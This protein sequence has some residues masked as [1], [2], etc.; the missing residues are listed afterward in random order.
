MKKRSVRFCSVLLSLL[1]LT[2][3][4]TMLS[5]SAAEVT[6]S[7]S[8]QGEIFTVTEDENGIRFVGPTGDITLEEDEARD[9]VEVISS[10]EDYYNIDSENVSLSK[11]NTLL[12]ASASLPDSVDNSQSKYFPEIGNQGS[13]GS[14]TCWAQ[15]Y[16]QFTYTMNKDMGV[17]T[18]PENAFSPKWTYNLVNWGDAD[19]GSGQTDV[20]ELMREIGVV[21]QGTVPY[22]D[23]VTSWSPQEDI[24][25]QALR[26]RV[27]SYQ[28]FDSFGEEKSQVTSVDDED[29]EAVKTA[30]SNGDVL[31]FSTH[32]NSWVTGKLKT[33]SKAPGNASHANE[34]VVLHQ[35]GAIGGHRMTIVGYNDN[36]W[37]DI[38]GNNTVDDGEM[39]AFKIANSWGKSYANSGFIWVAYDAL[40]QV[41]CVE[42]AA[43]VS[44]RKTPITYVARMDVEPYDSKSSIYLKYTLNTSCR[45]DVQPYLIAEKDGTEHSV[46]TLAKT[47]IGVEGGNQFSFDGTTNSNDG[48]MLYPLDSVIEDISTENLAD[49]NW[50]VRFVDKTAD[51][52]VLTVKDTQIVDETTNTVYKPASGTYPIKLDG[53]ET[54]IELIETTI[55]HAVVYYRGYENAQLTYKTNGSWKTVSMEENIERDGYVHKYVI[56]LG[57]TSTATFYF[58]DGNGKTDNNSGKYYTAGKGISYFVTENARQAVTVTL[59]MEKKGSECIDVNTAIGFVAEASGGYAPYTYQFITEDLVTNTVTTSTYKTSNRTGYFPRSEGDHRITVNVKD[60]SGAIATATYDIYIDDKP[61][62]FKSFEMTTSSNILTGQEVGFSARTIN[63]NL[64]YIGYVA[65]TYDI[66]VEKDG[67]ECYS[68]TVK[69]D[70]YDMSY[71]YT[72]TNFTWTPTES[73]SYTVKISSTDSKSEYAEAT[74]SFDV[75]EF[76]GTI[77]GDADNNGVVSIVDATLIQKYCAGQIGDSDIWKTLADSDKNDYINIKD[78][79]YIQLYLASDKSDVYVGTVNYKEPEPTTEP[80]TV[81]PTTVQ[82]TTVAET[83]TVVFT[84]SLNWSGTISCY[85]WSDS[86]TS[87]TSWPGKAMTYTETNSYGQKQ[88]SFEVPDGATYVIFTNGSSQTV[89]IP[90]PGGEVRYYALSTTD[91]SGHYNVETW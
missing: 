89:D 30:L 38:N 62:A 63:E 59:D 78:A 39:G 45:A 10:V 23:N 49:Y 9:D 32:I 70:E 66:T 7:Q 44:N 71:R 52:V 72:V 56:D 69:C 48:T 65:N 24:W 75:A 73:G 81:A 17:T 61:F 1:T 22:D 6:D 80:T 57:S 16:Y 64:R 67:S 14:C 26:Y 13:I 33:N 91:S 51:N 42:G 29:I 83:N 5:T 55:N 12:R 82:P 3:M 37:T 85:Y 46:Y 35:S 58:S 86:N 15:T 68:E 11:Q 74:V 60:H 90:Y 2:S 41:S 21:T 34:Y 18:T 54:R 4:P 20:Y 31:T 88:Y 36:I 19:A 76:N 50:S 79:T 25:R 28:E 47:T 87:M 40:N 43:E 84:N 77:I 53:D 27:K 8:S